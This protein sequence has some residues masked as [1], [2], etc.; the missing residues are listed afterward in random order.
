MHKGIRKDLVII[1]AE[2]ADSD[3]NLS[4]KWDGDSDNLKK[5]LSELGISISDKTPINP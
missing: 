3:P 1:Q 5:I 2:A 4:F